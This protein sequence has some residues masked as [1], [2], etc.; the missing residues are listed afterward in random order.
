MK[1]KLELNNNK[2]SRLL[3]FKDI[4]SSSKSMKLLKSLDFDLKRKIIDKNFFQT[5][6]KKNLKN[7][8]TKL[9]NMRKFRK[10]NC[11]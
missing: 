5:E 8:S 10:K 6:D 4:N 3:N 1:N 9:L 2:L 11:K 7:N